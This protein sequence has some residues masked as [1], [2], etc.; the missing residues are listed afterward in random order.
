M[1]PHVTNIHKV[2]AESLSEVTSYLHLDVFLEE[3]HVATEVERAVAIVTHRTQK[4]VI[5][6][7][8]WTAADVTRSQTV[9]HDD[10]HQQIKHLQYQSLEMIAL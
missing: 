5:H 3:V 2:L 4:Y 8:N 7:N 1:T 10:T 6:K 9:K